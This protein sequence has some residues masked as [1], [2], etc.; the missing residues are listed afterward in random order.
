MNVVKLMDRFVE[1]LTFQLRR[2]EARRSFVHYAT[3][4]LSSLERKSI[5]PI[6]ARA[7]PDHPDSSHQ[8]LHHL[9]ADSPWEDAPV[10]RF[11]LAWGLWA[12]TSRAPISCSIIDDTAQLKQGVHSVAVA[13]QYA[14]SVGKIANCQVS[15]TLALATKYD[16]VP[17]DLQLYLPERWASDAKR[18]AKTGVPEE[19]LYEPKWMIALGMLQRAHAEGVPLGEV[20]LADSDYGRTA[21]F[22]A[23]LRD[24]GLHYGVGVHSDQQVW[25]AGKKQT[26]QQIAKALPPSRFR[27]RTWREGSKGKMQGRFARVWIL[28]DNDESDPN[29]SVENWLLIED[30]GSEFRYYLSS[31]PRQTSFKALVREIKERW[32]TEQMNQ[33]LKGEL[34]FDHFEGRSW[35]GWNH[36]TS[37]VLCCY[38]LLLASKALAFSPFPFERRADETLEVAA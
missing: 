27:L 25:Y 32:R 26:V 28:V 16:T 13:R 37:V 7:N 31:R 36:H 20:T 4:L 33:E 11:A 1:R 24:L 9:I 3:G 6:A 5:E 30:R 19:L 22:R 35:R 12:A 10:R 14:G 15:V 29:G 18:R 21:A 23:G 17:V 8:A 38:H 2:S 34:G